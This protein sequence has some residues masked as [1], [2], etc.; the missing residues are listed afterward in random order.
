MTILEVINLYQ[1]SLGAIYSPSEAKS[2]T[3]IMVEEVT[4]LSFLSQHI[5]AND[6]VSE[7]QRNLLKS[8]L[9]RL[10]QQEPMQHVLGYELFC[11]LQFDVNKNVL[12]PRPETEDLVRWIAACEPGA[13]N[14]LDIG[15][16]SGCIAISLKYLLPTANVVG[17]DVSPE[18]IEIAKSNALKNKLEVS[19]DLLD[20]LQNPIQGNFDVIVSNPPYV[21]YDEKE[22]MF[23][24]VL[25]FEPALALFS[26]QPIHFY[27]VIAQKA[28]SS[29]IKGGKLYFEINEFYADEIMALLVGQGYT[30]VELKLD[31]AEKKRMVRAVWG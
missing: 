30:D 18:A 16:G 31:F 29:L 23:P 3:K 11:G 28:Q 6:L 9:A 12:I 25:E 21:G 7:E 15:T 14:I 10:L 1:D 8:H 5:K 27:D 20:I 22:M 19:F 2:I 4:G 26:Q 17:V 13:K 24:N